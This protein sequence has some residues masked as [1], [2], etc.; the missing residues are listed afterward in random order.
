MSGTLICSNCPNTYAIENGIPYMV[1]TTI[2]RGGPAETFGF[3]WRSHGEKKLEGQTVFGRTQA[4]DLEYFEEAVGLIPDELREK[5]ILD[6]G[7]GSGQLTE[8]IGKMYG[9]KAVIGVDVNSA[10]EF[11]FNRC[12]SL[13]N[14]HILQAEISALPFRAESFDLVWCNGVIH[15]MPDPPQLFSSLSRLV[16]VTGRIYIWVYEKSWNPFR[17]T[18]DFLG[19]YWAPVFTFKDF[20]EIRKGYYNA[21]FYFAQHLSCY[22]VASALEVCYIRR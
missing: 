6:A 11:P 3:E 10:I 5:V 22:P 1:V 13:P 14:V 7:C 16:R 9:A 17:F 12:R 8:G 18:K 4:Q 20:A 19:R 15:H 21:I 2:E